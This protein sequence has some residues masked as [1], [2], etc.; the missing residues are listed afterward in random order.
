M[1]AAQMWR[2]DGLAVTM[3]LVLL[4]ACASP[5]REIPASIVPSASA[6]P[7]APP[8]TDA[9]SPAAS[10]LLYGC[11]PGLDR[12]EGLAPGTYVTAGQ[13]A[14][15]TGLT[16]TVPAG[17]SSG[18]QDAGE[19][20]LH[21]QEDVDRYRGLAF[22]RDM[23]AWVANRPAP[24]LGVTAD[25]LVT[26]LLSDPRLD[27]VEG[28]P[29]TFQRYAADGSVSQ[30]V[31]AR[32]VTVMLA[33][34]APKEVAEC[35]A[36]ACADFLGDPYHW[37]TDHGVGIIRGH[38]PGEDELP[39]M[40]AA[41]VVAD[42]SECP[43]GNVFKVYVAQLG[44]ANTFLASVATFGPDHPDSLAAALADLEREV[45]PILASVILPWQIVAN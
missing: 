3:V 36:T 20:E 17:W 43:C 45:E 10:P 16:V 24:E 9:P 15:L 39:G 25:D 23:V 4:A 34:D 7:S 44:P 1:T 37:G 38:V 32:T 35:P 19:F 26:Y 13:Y 6:S 8:A 5:T 22:W 2:R 40:I 11:E 21:P 12:C 33:A 14:F 27:V 42:A 31:T 41:G 18:E 30:T 29:R 28:E